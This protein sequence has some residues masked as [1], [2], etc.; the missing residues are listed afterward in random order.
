MTGRIIGVLEEQEPHECDP[1]SYEDPERGHLYANDAPV[2]TVWRCDC[3]EVYVRDF[4]PTNLPHER[5]TY[6]RHLT[7][8][9]KRKALRRL[10][11]R[12]PSPDVAIVDTRPRGNLVPS[13]AVAGRG[14]SP[15]HPPP[16]PPLTRGELDSKVEHS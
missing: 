14:Q 10:V 12:I 2:G 5:H 8:R 4:S 3:G 9:R 6:W 13:N 7:G 1:G 15:R 16:P 11:P